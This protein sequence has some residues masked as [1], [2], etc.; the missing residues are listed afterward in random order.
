MPVDDAIASDSPEASS[1]VLW[2]NA[3]D[4]MERHVNQITAAL[5]GSERFPGEF[6]TQIPGVPLPVNLAPRA[7]LLVA[8]QRDVEIEL[9]RRAGVLG[10]FIFGDRRPE[11]QTGVSVDIRS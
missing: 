1:H 5:H 10:A 2:S 11:M 3:L 8:R 9:R 6:A 4:S 7:Q